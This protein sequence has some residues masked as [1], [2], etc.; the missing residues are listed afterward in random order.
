[1]RMAV[2]LA[3]LSVVSACSSSP[4]S[5]STTTSLATAPTTATTSAT[6]TTTLEAIPIWVRAQVEPRSPT[7]GYETMNAVVAFGDQL[8]AAGTS[9]RGAEVWLSSDGLRWSRVAL[10]PDLAVPGSEINDMILAGPGLVGAGEAGGEDGYSPAVWT[11]TD[12]LEWTLVSPDPPTFER[13]GYGGIAALTAGPDRLVAVGYGWSNAAI[14]T[15]VD[16]AQWSPIPHDDDLFG[17]A[18]EASYRT[19]DDVVAFEGGFVAVGMAQD[20]DNAR[21][22]VWLSADGITW[23]RHDAFP[24]GAVT[25]Y[26]AMRS[27]AISNGSLIAVGVDRPGDTPAVWSSNNGVEWTLLR[28][29]SHF[30]GRGILGTAYS[31]M[32][33]VIATDGGMLA[34]GSIQEAG[35]FDGAVWSSTDGF[36]WG[37]EETAALGGRWSQDLNSAAEFA[38]GIAV[39]GTDT[40]EI[41]GVTAAAW[42]IGPSTA[43]VPTTTTTEAPKPTIVTPPD[44]PEFLMRCGSRTRP[45]ETPPPLTYP[46]CPWVTTTDPFWSV[47]RWMLDP[48]NPP[49][50]SESVLHILV[51]EGVCANVHTEERGIRTILMSSGNDAVVFV[52]L[53]PT[54]FGGGCIIGPGVPLTIDLG[55]PLGELTVFEGFF[56]PPLER[57]PVP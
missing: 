27:V 7:N 24:A 25:G 30:G 45:Y 41:G 33:A 43:V 49:E 48:A 26:Q 3:A 6:T 28:R 1:M 10:Q 36:S 47:A 37:R 40:T 14:W 57:Y 18:S 34:V 12:G 9:E 35:F 8:V 17:D 29:G 16:G 5:D 13:P 31:E 52:L 23:S 22:S 46:D 11:S 39:I 4:A 42:F 44:A 21:A 56:V 53:E 38:G 55:R 54:G 19:I 15:S 51:R 20:G 2:L 32:R 50:P